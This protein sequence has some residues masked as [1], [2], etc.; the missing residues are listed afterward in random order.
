MPLPKGI[1]R[2]KKAK[3]VE[4]LNGPPLGL[5]EHESYT[6]R[7]LNLTLLSVE[8]APVKGTGEV[9]LDEGGLERRTAGA[10]RQQNHYTAF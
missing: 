5:G 10:K 4:L 7:A 6:V 3:L 8:D 1:G 2:M 9:R